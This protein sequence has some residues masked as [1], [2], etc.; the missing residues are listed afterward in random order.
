MLIALITS[1][2][3]YQAL[4]NASGSGI[5][6]QEMPIAFEINPANTQGLD[7]AA[8]EANIRRAASVWAGVPGSDI[9]F[10]VEMTDASGTAHDGHALVY[11]TDDWTHDP[12]LLALTSNWSTPEGT[13]ISF[14]IAI[15]DADHDWSLS[16]ESE[17]SDLQNTMAHEFGHVLGLG[18]ESEESEATMWSSSKRGEI[19]KRDLHTADEVGVV[20]LYANRDFGDEDQTSLPLACSSLAAGHGSLLALVAIA[21]ARRRRGK[22]E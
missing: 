15:N 22:E 5:V 2:H 11:F 9:E 18:H 10:D 21:F 17:H 12:N 3:A 19:L 14:D 8:V 6:W 7:E 13:I 20:S 16:G 4:T 1:A